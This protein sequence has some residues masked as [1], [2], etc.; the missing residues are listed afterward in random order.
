MHLGANPVSVEIVA[1]GRVIASA[2]ATPPTTTYYPFGALWGAERYQGGPKGISPNLPRYAGLASFAAEGTRYEIRIRNQPRGRWQAT[3]QTRVLVDVLVDGISVMT[4]K[5]S[6]LGTRNRGYVIAP[7]S[8]YSIKGWRIDDQSV[9][10]FV[11]GPPEQ[12]LAGEFG[13]RDK[14]GQIDIAVSW[15]KPKMPVIRSSNILP[16][17]GLAPRYGIGSAGTSQGEQIV[18]KVRRTHFQP[19]GRSCYLGFR[20]QIAEGTKSTRPEAD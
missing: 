6:S 12:S 1:D 8:T 16:F 4:G 5:P 18:S 10:R 2:T 19:W 11:V 7:L 9:R 20:Y 13:K 14:L 3:L 15:E 17:G